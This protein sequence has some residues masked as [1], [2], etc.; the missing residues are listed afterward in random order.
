L[1]WRLWTLVA[2]VPLGV[3]AALAIQD[4]PTALALQLGAAG[5]ALLVT[6]AA[7]LAARLAHWMADRG[8]HLA[9]AASF[10]LLAIPATGAVL[11]GLFPDPR[12]LLAAVLASVALAL[13]RAARVS[14]P[15]GSLVGH[16][17][18]VAGMVL[19]FSAAIV[20]AAGMRAAVV[21]PAPLDEAFAKAVY[22]LDARVARRPDPGCE[23][24]AERVVA[25][26]EQ[27]A[28]PWLDPQGAFVWFDAP[29]PDGRR[30]VHRLERA[31][32]EVRCWTCGEPGNNRRPALSPVAAA[33]VFDTDRHATWRHPVNTEVH[34]ITARGEEG[35]ALAS[36]RL[37]HDPEPDDHALYDPSGRGIVWSRGSPQG[38]LV[39]RAAVQSGH[40][41]LLLAAPRP[42]ATGGLRWIAPLAWAPDA[43]ALATGRGHW[44]RLDG[45][46][47]DPATGDVHPLERDLAG[48]RSVS[49]SADGSRIAV[50]ASPGRG[51]VRLLPRWLGFLL[52]RLR[53][54][55]DAAPPV[56]AITAVRIGETDGELHS[57]ELGEVA[58][59]GGPTGIALDADGRAFVLG[60]RRARESE[61]EERLLWI[62]LACEPPPP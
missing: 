24:R 35:P 59:W 13:V 10:G 42:L 38:Y 45:R 27:G 26:A 61:P 50:A 19:A 21:G 36:R 23:A 1:L 57:V 60:Q 37:T 20:V 40:G 3:L 31:S 14:G 54:I 17:A 28:H 44:R 9:R 49:F 18:G 48:P 33:L 58:S 2:G 56:G 46:L 43:R 51:A 29:G 11:L 34:L 32:G 39:V 55:L 7:S 6:A 62:E 47:T 53:P 30:Q 52:A 41:G 22:D 25:L 16:V 12:V 15:P 8:R 4:P 5:G